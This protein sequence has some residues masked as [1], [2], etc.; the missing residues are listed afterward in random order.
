M[1]RSLSEMTL[2]ELQIE[3]RKMVDAIERLEDTVDTVGR[4][5]HNCAT[6]LRFAIDCQLQAR[7]P[8]PARMPSNIVSFMQFK[9]RREAHG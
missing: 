1:K 8:V 9:A 7:M 5:Q 6:I 3:R 4:Y 2:E